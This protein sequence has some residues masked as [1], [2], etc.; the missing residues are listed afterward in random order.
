[1][2]IFSEDQQKCIGEHHTYLV[3][4]YSGDGFWTSTECKSMQEACVIAEE[5]EREHPNQQWSIMKKT[6][7]KAIVAH[8]GN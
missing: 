7:T 8:T 2:K 3:G 5:L 6:V 1:M 4:K